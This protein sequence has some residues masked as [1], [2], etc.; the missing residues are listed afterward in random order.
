MLPD[1]MTQVHFQGATW[2]KE[3][4]DFY[5]FSSDLEKRRYRV[6][7]RVSAPPSFLGKKLTMVGRAA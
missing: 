4:A 7:R 5:E 3:R 1:L 6:A 2:E